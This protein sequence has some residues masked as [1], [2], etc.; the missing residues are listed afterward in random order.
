MQLHCHFTQMQSHFY[1]N[2]EEIILKYQLISAIDQCNKRIIFQKMRGI[3][4]VVCFRARCPLMWKNKTNIAQSNEILLLNQWD[5]FLS[6]PMHLMDVAINKKYQ[7]KKSRHLTWYTAH[8]CRLQA[9]DNRIYLPD[10]FPFS[11]IVTV[12]CGSMQCIVDFYFLN[13][14]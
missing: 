3:R 6:L 7:R 12:R 11:I 8:H 13:G 2:R 10:S 9:C 14:S 4:D 5:D 1:E